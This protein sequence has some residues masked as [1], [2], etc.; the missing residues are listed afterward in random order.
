MSVI[1]IWKWK[2]LDEDD[3]VQAMGAVAV[4]D[5]PEGYQNY[6]FADGSGGVS[7]SPDDD[8]EAQA[9]R[10][11]VFAKW[12]HLSVHQAMT[13]GEA[14]MIGPKIVEILKGLEED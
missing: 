2:D 13:E 9:I 3:L 6:V 11:H 10:S 8:L 5:Y 12:C 14:L 1:T 4:L 7:I